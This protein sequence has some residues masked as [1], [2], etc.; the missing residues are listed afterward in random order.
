MLRL[1]HPPLSSSMMKR[2]GEA[3]LAGEEMFGL[4]WIQELAP[5]GPAHCGYFSPHCNFI[6]C[7]SD[8]ESCVASTHQTPKL[9]TPLSQHAHAHK[10]SREPYI[11]AHAYISTKTHWLPPSLFTLSLTH[12][13]SL[14]TL[15][16]P[17]W[18]FL[19]LQGLWCADWAGFLLGLSLPSCFRLASLERRT[20]WR[21]RRGDDRIG[22]DIWN[23]LW[24]SLPSSL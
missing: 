18:A 16:H 17:C 14:P 11:C 19:S 22:F 21:E 6:S 20:S 8:N 13:H 15:L 4:I 5:C 24:W 3:V 1:I 12:S 23:R 10:L 9:S 2:I 7:H